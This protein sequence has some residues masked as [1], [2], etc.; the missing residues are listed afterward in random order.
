MEAA[1]KLEGHV[2]K[3]V[4]PLQHASA[5]AE[6]AKNIP[7]LPEYVKQRLTALMFDIERVIGGGERTGYNWEG[8]QS[9]PYKYTTEGSLQRGIEALRKTVP[10][11]ALKEAKAQPVL[12]KT[13]M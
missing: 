11:D 8:S 10:E 4:K 13:A 3:I 7:N 1:D 2:A 6:E 9:K 12:L 5:T